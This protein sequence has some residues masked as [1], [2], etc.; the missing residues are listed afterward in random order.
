[1][2]RMDYYE[3]SDLQR[4]LHRFETIVDELKEGP[5]PVPLVLAK[6]FLL[7]SLPGS[8]LKHA[9]ALRTKGHASTNELCQDILELKKQVAIEDHPS[10]ASRRH[11]D[12]FLPPDL[13]RYKYMGDGTLPDG[14][15]HLRSKKTCGACLMHGHKAYAP[16]CPQT[17]ARLGLWGLQK[18]GQRPWGQRPESNRKDP[19]Q[20]LGIVSWGDVVLERV[21]FS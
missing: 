9:A 19:R 11:I 3:E 10:E 18:D 5:Y 7:S 13:R 21:Y 15:L 16:K 4:Y 8:I 20:A 14:A 6:Q 2:A 12:T 17:E 1:M